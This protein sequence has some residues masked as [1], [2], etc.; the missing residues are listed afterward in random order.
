MDIIIFICAFVLV[1]ICNHVAH[2]YDRHKVYKA[3]NKKLQAESGFTNEEIIILME[4]RKAMYPEV[5]DWNNE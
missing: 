3:I 2:L 1:V 4:L 5:E